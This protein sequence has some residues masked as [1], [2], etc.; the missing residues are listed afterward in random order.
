MIAKNTVISTVPTG[1]ATGAHG[2]L[3]VVTISAGAPSVAV[4]NVVGEQFTDAKL[5][6]QEDKF[7]VGKPIRQT[8]A[9]APGTVLEQSPVSGKAAEGSTV[10]LTVAQAPPNVTVPQL[11]G[12]TQDAASALLGKLGLVPSAVTEQRSVNPQYNNEVLSQYPVH[13]TSVAP[14]TTV[15]IRVESYVPPVVPPGSTGPTGPGGP[16]GSSGSSGVG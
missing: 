14:A 6:L 2:S 10:T 4:P 13:G 5:L 11:R 1:G 7:V 12:L 15:I 3:V 9:S 8:S 16:A